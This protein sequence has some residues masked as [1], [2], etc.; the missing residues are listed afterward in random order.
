MPAWAG[1]GPVGP[2]HLALRAAAATG[3]G[4]LGPAGRAAVLDAVAAWDGGHP[5]LGGDP[6]G[7]VLAAADVPPAERPGARLALL[8]ALA[9]YRI[10]EQDVAAWRAERGADPTAGGGTGT[11]RGADDGGSA[12][13]GGRPGDDGELTRVLA[14]G[15]ITATARVE[16]WITAETGG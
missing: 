3:G 1:D 15:A 16:S 2:A 8:A 11:G 14:F 9:P 4:L 5:P 10:T 6:V 12:H 7:P 13:H